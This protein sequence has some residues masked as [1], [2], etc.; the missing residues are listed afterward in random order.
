MALLRRYEILIFLLVFGVGLLTWQKYDTEAPIFKGDD[1][2]YL[3]YASLLYEHGTFGLTFGKDKGEPGKANAP[4]Y[5][6]L[7]AGVMYLDKS[8]ADNILCAIENRG[9][10][11]CGDFD[12]FFTLQAL[13]GLLSLLLIYLIAFKYSGNRIIAWIASALVFASGI[14]IEFSGIF[15]TEILIFPASCALVLFCLLFYQQKKLMWIFSIAVSLGFLTLT[16]PSYLYLFYGFVIFFGVLAVYLRDKASLIR[17]AVLVAVF[18][19]S[20]MPWAIRNKIHFDSFALNTSNYGRIIL[21]QRVSYNDMSWPEVGVSFVYWL[22]QFG[23]SLAERVF[24][25]KYYNRLGW[26]QG[27]YYTEG[28]AAVSKEMRENPN[29]EKEAMRRMILE[30]VLSFKHVIVSIPLALR[31]MYHWGLFGVVAFSALLFQTLYRKDYTLLVISLPIF[32]MVAFHAGL[33]VSIA[34]Y[35]VPLVILY[36][37]SLSWY[38]TLLG[39]KIVKKARS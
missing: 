22:P 3:S 16:R 11:G 27:T 39:Q 36:A 37:L 18:I 17:L 2:R 34:R 30:D 4:L 10:E 24:P 14:L 21:A 6:A 31:G 8:F 33:S 5:P 13:L 35:N 29:G 15:M 20:V 38:I 25:E 12:I 28:Y 19:V 32:F 9:G 26:D 1:F 23:D 7:I